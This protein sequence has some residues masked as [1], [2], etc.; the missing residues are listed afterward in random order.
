MYTLAQMI[1]MCAV[2]ATPATR[3]TLYAVIE[4]HSAGYP[5][6]VVDLTKGKRFETSSSKDAARILGPL[7]QAN[8]DVRIGLAGLHP[9]HLRSFGVTPEQALEPCVNI[10]LASRVLGRLAKTR[11]IRALKG[12][13][14]L[15]GLV[16]TYYAPG[17]EMG[18]V[19]LGFGARVVELG[20]I[21]VTRELRTTS[22]RASMT[23]E[24]GRKHTGVQRSRWHRSP[25]KWKRPG[26]GRE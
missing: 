16:A 8:F 15:H 23:Y 10:E 9:V 21:S 22:P 1:M 12:K 18:Q 4:T 25:R 3:D 19:A 6:L 24:L 26:A 20:P 7:M 11:S 14:R 17:K 2:N 13:D 5:H